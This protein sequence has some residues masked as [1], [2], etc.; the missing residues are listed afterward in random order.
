MTMLSLEPRP[1]AVATVKDRS[2]SISTTAVPGVRAR[3][4]D[5]FVGGRWVPAITDA[6]LDEAAL[7]ART[8]IAIDGRSPSTPG[9]GF[10]GP[11]ILEQVPP[12]GKFFVE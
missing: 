10:L 7:A 8:S 1:R 2:A 3:V 9:V 12:A 5:N 11:T 4:L 6:R